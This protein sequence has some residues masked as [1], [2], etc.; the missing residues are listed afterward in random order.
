M[1]RLV[2][3][4]WE[5]DKIAHKLVSGEYICLQVREIGQGIATHQFDPP[6]EVTADEMFSALVEFFQP[7]QERVGNTYVF[8][9]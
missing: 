4:Q 8:V 2:V 1:R 5:K 3:S 6:G 9:I 7:L